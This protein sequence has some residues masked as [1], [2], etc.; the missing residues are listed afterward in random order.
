MYKNQ[1]LPRS[2][3]QS[4]RSLLLSPPAS[5]PA[6]QRIGQ[7]KKHIHRRRKDDAEE[8]DEIEPEVLVVGHGAL[9]HGVVSVAVSSRPN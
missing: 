8:Q 9:W 4:P 6:N 2:S 1:Q 7:D 5:P 3:P